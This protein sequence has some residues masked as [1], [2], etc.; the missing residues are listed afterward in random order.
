[1]SIRVHRLRVVIVIVTH[2]IIGYRDRRVVWLWS[3][4]RNGDGKRGVVVDGGSNI[5]G[6]C[7]FARCGL[8]RL[9]LSGQS[10]CGECLENR[11]RVRVGVLHA[12]ADIFATILDMFSNLLRVGTIGHQNTGRTVQRL[13]SG[14]PCIA[15]RYV[16][17]GF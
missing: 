11:I 13:V 1:M 15:P 12:A 9:L 8:W 14:H 17:R 7:G 6:D 3:G 4:R 10:Y 16:Q 5:G 2:R